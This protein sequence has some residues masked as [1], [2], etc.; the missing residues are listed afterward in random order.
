MERVGR[1]RPRELL[2]FTVS[3]RGVAML[4]TAS[5]V[6]VFAALLCWSAASV[7]QEQ[8]KTPEAAVDALVAAAKAGAAKALVRLMGPDGKAMVSSGDPV[9]DTNV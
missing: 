6:P 2:F 1:T 7:T 5:L 3:N 8:F 4:R 9:T